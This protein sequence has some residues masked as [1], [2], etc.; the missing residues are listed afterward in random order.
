MSTPRRY[1]LL[2]GIL[3]AFVLG[4]LFGFILTIAIPEAPAR[5]DIN[6][7]LKAF[8]DIFVR[9][10]RI[11]IPML[12]FFTISAATSSIANARKL[13]IILLWMLI[14]Y[15]GTSLLAA[16]WGLIGGLI[17]QPGTATQLAPPA[18]YTPPKPPSGIDILL[19]FFQTDFNA[20]LAVEGSVSM[21]IFAIILGVAVVL[22]MGENGRIVARFLELGSELSIS[23]VRVIMYYAPI[24]VFCYSAWL[25]SQ[26]GPQM[27]Q[28]YASFLLV[29]Y[30]FSI[31][32]LIIVYSIIV[33]IGGLNPI[34][35]FKYQITPFI[36]AFTTRSS[37][38]ALPYN[39][40]AAKKMGVQDEVFKITLPIGATVNMD[41]TAL[42]QALSAVFIA[43][44]F[45]VTLTP[46]QYGLVLFAA[47]IGSIGTAAIPGGGT[48]M[49]AF[50]LSTL[51]LPIEGVGIMWVIDA[52]ADAMRTAINVSGDNACTI[53]VSRI[54]G[55]KLVKPEEQ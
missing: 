22:F 29:Q 16:F 35:Y 6:A 54:I 44:L 49:L 1:W 46:A 25:I 55:Y 26:Y 17:F 14:L 11:V 38:V 12:I 51:G 20:L 15:I 50:V 43:Q 52:F 23:V 47:L 4:V 42:Y 19:S 36:I 40:E 48:V 39:M 30:G 24:A 10:I 34:T 3:V 21:I 28:A 37:A 8:G 27:L 18:G 5:S 13:G 33:A 32:H 9:L 45:G 41:G 53:L 7:W 2:V 31:F